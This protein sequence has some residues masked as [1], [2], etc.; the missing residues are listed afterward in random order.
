[1]FDS[2]RASLSRPESLAIR[3]PGRRV[4]LDE[5]PTDPSVPDV[6]QV[7]KGEWAPH[8][9]IVGPPSKEEMKR[10]EALSSDKDLSALENTK[11]EK[12]DLDIGAL[13]KSL[14]SS[15]SPP[16]NSK[17]EGDDNH[18]APGTLAHRALLQ[19]NLFLLKKLEEYQETRFKTPGQAAI[20]SE[21]EL[22]IGMS[23]H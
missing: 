13:V 12:E 1:M 6:P 8:P 11:W 10:W 16:E 22:D 7:Y 14:A 23:I 3:I 5:A 2:E 4:F 21:N 9:T 20:V 15:T 19:R 17:A 18:P